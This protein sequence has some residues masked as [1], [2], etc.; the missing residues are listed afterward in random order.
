[1][2]SEFILGIQEF[3]SVRENPSTLMKLFNAPLVQNPIGRILYNTA[4]LKGVWNKNESAV[5]EEGS[6]VKSSHDSEFFKLFI[7]AG[8]K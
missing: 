6:S 5:R 2:G 4:D 3:R 1:M 7:Q 8:L